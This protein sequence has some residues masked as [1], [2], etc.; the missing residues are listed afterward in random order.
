MRCN[1]AGLARFLEWTISSPGP[2]IAADYEVRGL[3]R[4]VW[5]LFGIFLYMGLLGI[6]LRG[7]ESGLAWRR[8]WTLWRGEKVRLGTIR[9]FEVSTL[10]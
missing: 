6:S 8:R 7:V 5:P 4:G 2:L 1:G 10:K 3:T 9:L